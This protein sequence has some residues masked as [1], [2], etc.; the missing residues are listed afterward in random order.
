VPRRGLSPP[1]RAGAAAG[2]SLSRTMVARYDHLELTLSADGWPAGTRGHLVEVYANGTGLVEVEGAAALAAG[3][4]D[5][6]AAVALEGVRVLE[7]A[8]AGS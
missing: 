8:P 1:T 3:P 5:P 2:A 4:R 7:P 6:I